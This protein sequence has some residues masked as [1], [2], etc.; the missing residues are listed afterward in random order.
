MD[1]NRIAYCGV[2]CAAC[3]DLKDKKCPGCRRTAWPEGDACMPVECCRKRGI[4]FCGEC[5]GFPCADMK[6]FY[7]ESPGHEE[8][9]RRML[10]LS[11][12]LRDGGK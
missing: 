7:R 2:D 4:R 10:D 11:G 6:E 8:A 12:R 3:P 9:Y 1:E 5:P